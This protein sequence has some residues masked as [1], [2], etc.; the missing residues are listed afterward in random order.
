[1][2][3]MLAEEHS[4]NVLDS[5]GPLGSGET[6]W[7]YG[8]GAGDEDDLADCSNPASFWHRRFSRW[9]V[10]RD[11]FGKGQNGK[12]EDGTYRRW[13]LTVLVEMKEDLDR[14]IEG[15]LGAK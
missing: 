6:N 9:H 10:G 7:I 12:L 13:K 5:K 11:D 14:V 15:C 1:M 8:R 3:I 2:E 4:Q